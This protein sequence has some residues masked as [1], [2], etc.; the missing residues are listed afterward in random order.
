LRTLYRLL[1]FLKPFL[2]D[3]FLSVIAGIATIGSGIGMLGTSAFLISSAALHPSIADLQVAIVG[4]R[5]FGIS[6][7]VFRYLERL[8]SHSVNLKVLAHIRVWFYQQIEPQAPARL[9]QVRSGDLLN[10]IMPDLETLENF[11]VR[12]VSPMIVAGVITTGLSIFV[13]GYLF[14]L[15][16]ILFGGMFINGFVLPGISIMLTRKRGEQLLST[17]SA[18]CASM[19]EFFQGLE[20]LQ[21]GGA[22]D[23]WMQNIRES[24]KRLGLLQRF[25]G[26]L[27]GINN[28]LVLLVMNCT[29]FAVLMM[30][31]PRVNDGTITGVSLAVVTM[32]T[33]A[34]FEATSPLPLAAQN[35]TSSIAAGKRLF[36]ISLPAR[37]QCHETSD[38]SLRKNV[39][40]VELKNIQFHY[41]ASDEFSLHDVTLTLER[42]H[43]VALVGPSGAGKTS[44]V[45]LLLGFWKQQ[46]GQFLIDGIDIKSYS[47]ADIRSLFG[48]ISQSTYI[49]SESLRNNLLLAK[50]GASD[51]E[52]QEVLEKVELG[53]W[54]K[55]LPQGLDTWLGE[56]GNKMSGGERQR[57]VIA[58]VL[59]QDTP[60]VILD[61]PTS[62]LDPQ[63][64]KRIISTIIS[65]FSDRG[66]L[67]IT[68]QMN[69][70]TQMDQIYFLSEGRIIESRNEN[71]LLHRNGDYNR[72]FQ[73]QNQI[74]NE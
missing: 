22:E 41:S 11:Y 37:D 44:L 46:E 70:L 39:R 9:Q 58:R 63:T 71:E 36:E 14:E 74:I 7:S 40:K 18:L 10:R 61:E 54:F 50:P 51:V 12:V 72:F 34:G 4:V 49:F 65:T 48:V 35:L 38:I 66:I 3:V 5:F 30:A 64:E 21:A 69:L 6:R 67:L 33:M 13:G 60:F 2:K 62:N 45:N 55:N 43:K 59:L 57:L 31:I 27:T 15:G 8:I 32:L 56:R 24:D 23:R 1:K 19:V 42:G 53:A 29:V 28:G 52:I 68:H 26:M 73:L 16:V 17:R 20:D 25:N 47:E